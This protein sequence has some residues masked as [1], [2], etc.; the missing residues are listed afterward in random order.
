[1]LA[2]NSVLLKIS[3]N[4]FNF[5]ELFSSSIALLIIS[6]L[7]FSSPVKERFS[8][9]VRRIVLSKRLKYQKLLHECTEA[10][11]S[12]LEVDKL[13]QY[14]AVSLSKALGTRKLGI[15]L[16]EKYSGEGMFR[17]HA[18]MGINSI[19]RTYFSNQKLIGWLEENKNHPAK[20]ESLCLKEQQL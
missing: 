19:K 18:S 8:K 3:R 4:T 20:T 11:T 15:F 13:L 2:L 17:L 6:L 16:R 5:P 1:M 10:V 7:Y 14:V 12:I 9:M